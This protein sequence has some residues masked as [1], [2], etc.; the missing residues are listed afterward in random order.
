MIKELTPE[1]HNQAKPCPRV[2]FL[3]DQIRRHLKEDVRDEEYEQGEIV[4]IGVW[5]RHVK[6]FR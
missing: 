3:E 2:D 5:T 4:A 1:D 6:V